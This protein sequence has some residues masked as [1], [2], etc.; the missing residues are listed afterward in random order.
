MTAA[1]NHITT[2][3]QST[4]SAETAI[5]WAALLTAVAGG[6]F[7]DGAILTGAYRSSSPASEDSLA[8]PW[9][10]AT[11]VA[12]SS[13]WGLAQALMV[14]GLVAF[15]RGGAPSGRSG[16]GGAWLAVAG[17]V[18]Y[19]IAHLVSVAAY[20]ASTDDVGAIVAMSLFGAGTVALAVGLLLAGRS[21]LR[22]PRR[23]RRVAWA[24][25]ALGI[26]M[27]VMIPIQ[28][29]PALAVAVGGYAVLV[30]AFGVS[31]MNERSA[32]GW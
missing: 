31:L 26:W 2:T 28:F 4:G 19:T 24:P 9:Q 29:T 12:T 11:A 20:G 10:G 23:P 7:L 8:F 27:V 15:A 6:I 13:S 18:A 14:V 1:T 3:D 22:T 25:L 16:R 17:G 5:P 30:I 32:I 21:S